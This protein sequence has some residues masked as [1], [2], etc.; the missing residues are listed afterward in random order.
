M[1]AE[2]TAEEKLGIARDT[3]RGLLNDQY[4]LSFKTYASVEQQKIDQQAEIDLW[5]A[6][7]ANLEAEVAPDEV[8]ID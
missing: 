5:E 6:E 1:P 4:R 8:P 2:L 3:L 7:I